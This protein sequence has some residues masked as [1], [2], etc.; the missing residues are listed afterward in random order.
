MGY[1]YRIKSGRMILS[2]PWE[3]VWYGLAQWLGVDDEKL[4]EVLPNM[5]NFPR[6]AMLPGTAMFK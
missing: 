1:K 6:S 2:T 5:A 4:P 3:A